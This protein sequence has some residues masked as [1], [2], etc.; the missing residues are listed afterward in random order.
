MLESKESKIHKVQKSE[1]YIAYYCNGKYI[2]LSLR[3]LDF[4]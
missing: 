4:E 1:L 3:K 2:I